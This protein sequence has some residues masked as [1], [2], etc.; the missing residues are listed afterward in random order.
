MLTLYKFQSYLLRPPSKAKCAK[1]LVA[2]RTAENGVDFLS[3]LPIELIK[4][5][6]GYLGSEDIKTIQL[7]CTRLRDVA[8]EVIW[9]HVD[10]NTSLLVRDNHMGRFMGSNCETTCYPFCL[11]S[12][13]NCK[14][15]CISVT[16]DNIKSFL[17]QVLASGDG[18]LPFD[19]VK[20]LSFHVDEYT[21]PGLFSSDQEACEGHDDPASHFFEWFIEMI[22][23]EMFPRLRLIELTSGTSHTPLRVVNSLVR[24]LR[25]KFKNVDFNVEASPN[26]IQA[27]ISDLFGPSLKVLKLFNG[28]HAENPAKIRRLIESKQL[29]SSVSTLFIHSEIGILFDTKVLERFFSKATNLKVLSIKGFRTFQSDLTWVPKSVQIISIDNQNT[30]SG[31]KPN[32]LPPVFA[33]CS[34]PVTTLPQVTYLRLIEPPY[35]PQFASF[36][37]LQ[38]LVLCGTGQN[39]EFEVLVDNLAR[40]SPHIVQLTCKFMSYQQI[41]KLITSFPSLQSVVVECSLRN[42]LD[43]F[44]A[45]LN[46]VK[47]L[48]F[49][50]LSI[51]HI[52]DQWS[53]WDFQFSLENALKNCPNPCTILVDTPIAGIAD[54]KVTTP[55]FDGYSR[56]HLFKPVYFVDSNV[57]TNYCNF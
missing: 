43:G 49:I 54:Y 41:S 42:D 4:E 7:C 11:Y 9:E 27:D 17:N 45:F 52:M 31:K 35:M 1:K 50:H 18:S 56:V 10:L 29:C 24:L 5:V 6:I 19:V 51:S 39:H 53:C 12:H 23:P 40:N 57:L 15:I 38:K 46:A 36:P 13:H 21:F 37:N 8:K 3:S 48:S 16:T 44:K 32:E 28:P 30:Y 14:K 20:V 25:A 22:T 47:G 2:Q 26:D 34:Q 33:H 55:I